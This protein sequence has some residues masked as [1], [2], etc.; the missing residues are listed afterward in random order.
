MP[1]KPGTQAALEQQRREQLLAE[2]YAANP[3]SPE[4]NCTLIGGTG[5]TLS[6]DPFKSRLG[7]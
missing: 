3:L 1:A 6:C 2:Q 5:G 4:R 7:G